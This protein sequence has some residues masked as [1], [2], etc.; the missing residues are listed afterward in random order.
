[1]FVGHR[2]LCSQMSGVGAEV[3]RI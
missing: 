1:M 2:N 3:S